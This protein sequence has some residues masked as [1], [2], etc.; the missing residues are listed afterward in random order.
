[1]TAPLTDHFAVGSLVEGKVVGNAPQ[2]GKV[3]VP[4]GARVEGR[5][6]RLER[7]AD[8]KGSFTVA[9]EFTAIETPAG[10]VRFYATL[11]QFDSLEGVESPDAVPIATRV[12]TLHLNDRMVEHISVHQ[13]PGVGTF[14]INRPHFTLPAG[15]KT[16]WKTLPYPRPT[17]R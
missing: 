6:R 3:L 11:E 16:V 1:L 13:V 15:F 2:K 10:I 4:D 8:G 17:T 5:V 12:S 7:H 14:F 9:V